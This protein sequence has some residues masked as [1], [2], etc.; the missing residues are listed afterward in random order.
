MKKSTCIAA[1]FAAGLGVIA[2]TGVAL[3]M[4]A[5]RPA[6]DNKPARDPRACFDS[7]QVRS[8]QTEKDDKIIIISNW[9]EAYEL[10]MMPACIGLDSS[11]HIGIK[12]RGSGLNDICGPFDGEIVY[13]DMGDRPLKTCPIQAVRHLTPEEAVAYGVKPKADKLK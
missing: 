13:S 6:P 3:A 10:T 2:V 12:S 1:L 11:F 9:N 8:F 4:S 5:G 7:S